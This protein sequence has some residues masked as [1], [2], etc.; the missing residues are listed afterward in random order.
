[1][2]ARA[3]P[4]GE[5]IGAELLRALTVLLRNAVKDPRLG[6]ITLQEVRVSRDLAH[7]KVYFTAFPLDEDGVAR[8]RVLNGPLANFLRREL[9]RQERLRTIPRLHFVH[10]R[11]IAHGER[12]T[13]LIDAAVMRD[14]DTGR[15]P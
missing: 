7:A 12:L 8:E 5:R 10:D 14:L 1:V 13:A 6:Q 4:R 3:F 2:S 9:G 11:S 15:A